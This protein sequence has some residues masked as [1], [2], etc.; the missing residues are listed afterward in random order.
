MQVVPGTRRSTAQK[1]SVIA[2]PGRCDIVTE[3]G[4]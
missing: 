3:G 4:M 2:F 1:G